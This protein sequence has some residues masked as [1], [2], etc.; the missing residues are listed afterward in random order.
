MYVLNHVDAVANHGSRKKDYILWKQRVRRIEAV[1][2]HRHKAGTQKSQ[3]PRD[4]EVEWE[5]YKDRKREELQR[6]VADALYKENQGAT[7]IVR[8][9]GSYG[10]I[11]H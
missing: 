11:Y 4:Y 9:D 6:R 7:R 10:Y 5:G 3:G 1:A 2:S 8:Q